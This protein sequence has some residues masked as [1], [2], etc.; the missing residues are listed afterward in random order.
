MRASDKKA[1]PIVV[2]GN[3]TRQGYDHLG[4]PYPEKAPRPDPG[5]NGQVSMAENGE[6]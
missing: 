4:I 3:W 2:P 1:K 6:E 5:V